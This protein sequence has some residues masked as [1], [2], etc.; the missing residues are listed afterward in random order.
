MRVALRAQQ[1]FSLLELILVS[2]LGALLLLAA[3]QHFASFVQAAA[4]RSAW[5]RLQQE[6]QLADTLLKRDIAQAHQVLAAGRGAAYPDG[7]LVAQSLP[8]G[9]PLTDSFASFRSSDWMLLANVRP[10]ADWQGYSLWHADQKTHGFG[11]AHKSAQTASQLQS[12]QTLVAQVELLRLRFYQADHGQWLAADAVSDW[13][14]VKAVA[15]ALLLVSDQAVRH[16]PAEFRL[17]GET[18]M[19]PDDGRL[20]LLWTGSQLLAE[21]RP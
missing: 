12:S 4:G 21:D 16:T 11:L 6:A 17:W 20:R 8:G 18:L 5:L 10:A 1:G 14:A 9:L 2:A 7:Q 15:F 3:I 19:P 13:Q